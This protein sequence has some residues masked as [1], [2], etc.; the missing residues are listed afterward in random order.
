MLFWKIS[1][2]HNQSVHKGAD[3]PVH[4][5]PGITK[6]TKVEN[7]HALGIHL[8]AWTAVLAHS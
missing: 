7:P 6:F 4:I 3:A 5:L 1:R 8:I 2:A